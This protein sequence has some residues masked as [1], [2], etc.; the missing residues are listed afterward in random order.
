M[1]GTYYGQPNYQ[2][3]WQ[4][5]RDEVT[6]RHEV[7]VNGSTRTEAMQAALSEAFRDYLLT[8]YS[9]QQRQEFGTEWAPLEDLDGAQLI[10]EEKLRLRPSEAGKMSS[11]EL[12]RVLHRE[13]HDF[14]LPQNAASACH[15]DLANNELHLMW[16]RHQDQSDV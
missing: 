5:I 4:E 10:A 13:L 11:E 3:I 2:E 14:K 1:A 9:E 8:C 7:N 16:A 15:L 6:N 12:A